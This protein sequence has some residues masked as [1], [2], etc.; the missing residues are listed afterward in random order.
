M[1]SSRLT[2][3][4]SSSR[5]LALVEVHCEEHRDGEKDGEDGVEGIGNAEGL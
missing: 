4:S 3:S 5:S 2:C 1:A